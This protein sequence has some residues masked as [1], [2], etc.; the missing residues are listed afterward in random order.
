MEGYSVT[1][2]PCML[3]TDTKIELSDSDTLVTCTLND[4]IISARNS[5]N[6]LRFEEF[7]IK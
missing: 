5:H 1:C 7:F 2:M 3:D 6:F 4:D